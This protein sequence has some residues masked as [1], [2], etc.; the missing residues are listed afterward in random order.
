MPR[1]GGSIAAIVWAAI[2][3]WLFM[4]FHEAGHVV[5]TVINGGDIEQVVLHPFK[6]SQT[7]ST[8]SSNPLMDVW[9]GPIFGIALPYAIYAI[10]LKA[11]P[12]SR[13]RYMLGYLAGFC[14]VAN[15]VYIGISWIYPGHAD[16]H[17]LLSLGT[18][19]GA[20]LGFG[21]AAVAAGLCTWHRALDAYRRSRTVT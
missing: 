8:A 13:I 15:G 6:F 9:M 18:P 11:A 2:S 17:E 19:T 21:L 1:L 4:A 12:I 3:W 10:A 14:A 20:L 7:V 16:A 5:S